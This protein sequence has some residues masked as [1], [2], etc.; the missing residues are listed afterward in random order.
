MSHRV[1]NFGAGPAMLPLPVMEKIRDEFLDYNGMGTSV[2]EISHRS[3]EFQAIQ[4][5]AK[6][7]LRELAGIPD[8][9]RILFVHG[10]SY[11]FV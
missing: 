8:N 9:Y 11:N 4:D 3:K 1:Y 2:I 5:E 7:L 6:V 10:G